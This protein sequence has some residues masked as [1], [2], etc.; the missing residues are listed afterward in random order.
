MT[1]LLLKRSNVAARSRRHLPVRGR[2][3]RQLELRHPVHGQASTTR[4]SKPE[5]CLAEGGGAIR[6]GGVANY[7]TVETLEKIPRGIELV[8]HG[9]SGHGSIPLKSNAIV[10]LADAVGEGRA[11]AAGD[12]LQRDHRHLL[13]RPGA[14]SRRRR[15]RSY[16]RDVLSTGSRRCARA[17][18][19]WLFENEPL[20]SSMLRTSVSPNIIHG[21]LPLERDSVGSEGD[22]RR[23]RAARRGSGRRSSSRSKKIVND[24]A[25]RRPLHRA[26][27]PGRP[28]RSTR[29]ST[30]S[31][32]KVARGGGQADLQHRS[33][34]R[35]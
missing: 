30:R 10:H 22:A 20:H 8:A 2:R 11:V 23:A 18:D 5:Y 12:P 35:R 31:R 25:G 17:A 19:E 29:A 7:T 33:R 3:G 34:C 13:P 32:A 6:I 21:R 4:R 16:Y 27:H 24:P 1:M 28:R 26:E 15:R 9:I 14:R